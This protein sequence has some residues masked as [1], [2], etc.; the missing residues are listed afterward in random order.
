MNYLKK[1]AYNISSSLKTL[2]KYTALW[3][4]VFH[5]N[6]LYSQCINNVT[7]NN[8]DQGIIPN[9]THAAAYVNAED[10]TISSDEIISFESGKYSILSPGFYAEYGSVF[11]VKIVP[12]TI[13][14]DCSLSCTSDNIGQISS[15]DRGPFL[16]KLMTDPVTHQAE[17]TIK[18]RD[19]LNYDNNLNRFY[20]VE[21]CAGTGA[22]DFYDEN[23]TALN[24]E[25]DYRI[26]SLSGLPPN[27]MYQY[28]IN[29]TGS[30]KEAVVGFFTTS[31]IVGSDISDNDPV[32]FWVM[33]DG[34]SIS[35]TKIESMRNAYFDYTADTTANLSLLT[36]CNDHFLNTDFVLN[37]GD[38]AYTYGKESELQAA[39][40]D[41]YKKILKYLPIWPALGNH[42][43]DYEENYGGE[44]I[45]KNVFEL[46]E[47]V[48]SGVEELYYSFDYGNIHF[49]CLYTQ[50]SSAKPNDNHYSTNYNEM[51]TW[52]EADLNQAQAYSKWNV[53][54]FHKPV[55]TGGGRNQRSTMSADNLEVDSKIMRNYIGEI[56]NDYDIDLVLYGHNHHYER[57]YLTRCGNGEWDENGNVVIS[58]NNLNA[59][60]VNDDLGDFEI[61][62]YGCADD[63]NCD[64]H[65]SNYDDI[66]EKVTG[67]DNG[68]VFI[69]CGA[70]SKKQ[71]YFRSNEMAYNAAH[72]FFNHPAMRIFSEPTTL[73]SLDGTQ[74]I[75]NFGRGLDGDEY[76]GSLNFSITNNELVGAYISKNGILLDEFTIV[77]TASSFRRPNPTF[78]VYP[79]PFSQQS[80][81]E[82]MLTNEGAVT[83]FVSDITGK[84]V[85]TLSKEE[86]QHAGSHQITFNAKGLSSGIYYCTV[87]TND[88]TKTLKMVIAK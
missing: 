10:I 76:I 84:E 88:L 35:G 71:G 17:V 65:D 70:S 5:T 42:E 23:D 66:L 38:N 63:I 6:Q 36:D 31:P 85:A 28:N 73:N 50:F 29:Y 60:I 27:T 48:P 59:T 39:V 79:N 61:L 87:Q 68:T 75:T 74:S 78:K 41:P 72:N 54:Y 32:S 64:K 51:F 3:M 80:T 47:N 13:S 49:A 8:S 25:D 33:G 46:P 81:I 26:F 62:D 12:C 20:T 16:Q 37:L 58:S 40:F 43:S 18:W 55:L 30:S 4:F 7:Y 45:H 53:L 44:T 15:I 34:G 77:K 69:L 22:S 21:L 2:I 82:Y 52:L 57:S 19:T 67:A 9:V 56:T 1:E 86:S 24:K 11:S 14:E 83:I